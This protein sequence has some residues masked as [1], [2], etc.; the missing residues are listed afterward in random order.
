MVGVRRQALGYCREHQDDIQYRIAL[1]FGCSTRLGYWLWL[2]FRLHVW[3]VFAVHLQHD[4]P[5]Q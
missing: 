1:G 5:G 4:M 3:R 2:W